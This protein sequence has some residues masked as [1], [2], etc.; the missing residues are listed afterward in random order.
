MAR[1][2]ADIV[3]IGAGPAGEVIAGRLAE[4]GKRVML[5][6]H[7]LVGGECAYYACMPSKGLL[8]PA[9]VLHEAQR[10]GGAAEVAGSRPDPKATFARRDE[11]IHELDDAAQMPWLESREIE[12]VRGWARIEGERL[13][14]IGDE[15][16]EAAEAVVIAT[17]S[18]AALP[19]IEGIVEAQ[20]WTNREATTASVVP[21]RLIVVGGGPVGAEMAQA[22]HRL[23][24]EV[25]LVEAAEHLLPGE[26]PFAGRVLEE[27]FAEEGIDVRTGA[28]I[29]R[30]RRAGDSVVV[31]LGD[32][33]ELTADE[34]LVAAGRRARTQDI[35]LESIGVEPG[36]P[37]DVDAQLRVPGHDWLYAVG[38]VNGHSPLTHMGK[39]QARLA[40]D[41]IL[42]H[43]DAMLVDGRSSPRVVFTD[44][45]IA[46]VGRTVGDRRDEGH[47]AQAIDV[48]VAKVAGSSFYGHGAV[49]QARFVIDPE[50]QVVIGATFVA[51]E[52]AELLHAATI[53]IVG[54]VPFESL[55][56]AVPAFPTRS[57]LWLHV[58]DALPR[59]G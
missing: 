2:E 51:P 43:A 47:E 18:E 26:E 39:Y 49:A 34:L 4:N 41:C 44:P 9:E 42:G 19:E 40:A 6:E 10:V 37:L 50:R 48:D 58:V 25:A 36:A 17:G 23:G 15:L 20:P 38:D 24:A 35:G 29:G 13:V 7:E 59:A 52:A 31:D 54:Q 27:A 8:R 14:R 46:A 11:I 28:R 45:Q 32:D 3:V 55:R 5:A 57:E 16:V 30:I 21:D 33:G 1:R 12:L 56:H 53:A 22:W